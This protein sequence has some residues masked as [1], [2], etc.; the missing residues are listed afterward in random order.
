[1][2]G[3][4]SKPE[5]IARIAAEDAPFNP[6][7]GSPNP[8]RPSLVSWLLLCLVKLASSSLEKQLRKVGISCCALL[9][10]SNEV[11]YC[12]RQVNPLVFF[13]LQLGRYGDAVK[14]GRVVMV[15]RPCLP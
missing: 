7:L 2:G 3:G 13:D 12:C 4:E 14:L 5:D 15:G 8:V 1:M 6:P 11:T 10:P 9:F